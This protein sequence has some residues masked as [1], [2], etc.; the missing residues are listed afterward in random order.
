M[1]AKQKKEDS[2]HLRLNEKVKM[3][4]LGYIS[5]NHC[6]ISQ[7]AW[8]LLVDGIAAREYLSADVI[9]SN[10]KSYF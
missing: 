4:I 6:Q 5:E 9:K 3:K 7:E 2:V 8:L 10:R 1:T